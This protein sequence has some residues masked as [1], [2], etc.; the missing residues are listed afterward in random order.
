MIKKPSLLLIL[1]FLPIIQMSSL[2]LLM[3]KKLYNLPVTVY[4]AEQ[5]PDLSGLYLNQIDKDMIKIKEL[6]DFDSAYN[7]VRQGKS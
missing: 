7:E 2:C 1:F 5:P 3:G 4:N 6:P